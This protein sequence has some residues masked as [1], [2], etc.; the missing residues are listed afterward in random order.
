MCT[1]HEDQCT[2]LII[3]CSVLLRVKNV[4]DKSCRENQNTHFKCSTF[5]ENHA[6]YEIM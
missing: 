1:L 4:P 2:F 5:F 6:A 3:S